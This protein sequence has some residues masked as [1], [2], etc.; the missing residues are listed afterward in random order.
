MVFI[1]LGSTATI[2]GQVLKEYSGIISRIGGVILIV[3]GLQY[4]GIFR[5]PF[6]N[7][8][9]RFNTPSNVKIRLFGFFCNRDDI[10]IWMDPV[11]GHDTIRNFAYGKQAGNSAKWGTSPGKFFT[12][13]GASFY[14][15]R[16][17]HKFLFQ[18]LKKNKQAS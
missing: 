16:N 5:I 13:S 11:R 4:I 9:K 17:I 8:E 12:G 2:I 6:L 18:F 3:F 7:M 10:F 15:C 14:T 1:A